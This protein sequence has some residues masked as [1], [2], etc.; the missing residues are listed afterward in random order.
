MSTQIQYLVQVV[1]TAPNLF[2][3]NRQCMVVDMDCDGDG[4]LR[5]QRHKIHDRDSKLIH[6]SW[7]CAML[8]FLL[9]PGIPKIGSAFALSFST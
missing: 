9:N 5:M 8:A 6:A 7:M 2:A 3:A 4:S 1:V